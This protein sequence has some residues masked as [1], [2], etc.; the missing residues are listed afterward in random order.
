MNMKRFIFGLAFLATMFAG[1][2]TEPMN[3][4]SITGS[5]AFEALTEVFVPQTKTS[6][7]Q[8][9]Q[10]VW[11]Q[12]DRLAIFRGCTVADEFLVTDS[13]AGKTNGTFNIVSDNSE[14]NGSFSAGTEAPCN[15]A[16]YPYAE[17]I[18]LLGASL[19]AGTAYKIDGVVI[20]AVQNYVAGSFGNGSFPMV[21]V[22]ETISDHTLRFKN[23]LGAMK[24]QFKGA[25]KIVSIKVEGKNNETLSGPA[26]ITAYA[27]DMT[28]AIIMA[29]T[30]DSAKSVTLDCGDGVQLS[31]SIV[32]DFIIALPPVNFSDGFV[33]KVTDADGDSFEIVADVTNTVIRSSI[34]VMP[35]VV[36]DGSTEGESDGG[37][38]EDNE[39][40]I[41]LI[42]ASGLITKAN[43]YGAVDLSNY[44]K[45]ENFD[46]YAYWANEHEGSWFTDA[47][48]FLTSTT[49]GLEFVNKGTSWGGL[50]PYY[51][52]KNGSLRFAAYSP[53]SL[54][55]AHV[56]ETDT[57]IVNDY[58]QSNETDKTC[59]L[60]LAPTSSSKT[61]ENDVYIGFQ[62]ALSW[63]TFKVRATNTESPYMFVIN[64]ITIQDVYT[65]ADLQASMTDGIQAHEWTNHES[66][67]DYIVFDGSQNLS[68]DY[69]NIETIHNG[70][71]LIPQET[72]RVIV[73][74]TMMP[75]GEVQS[76]SMDLHI[77]SDQDFWEPNKH[78]VYSLIFSMHEVLLSLSVTGFN[79]SFNESL[80]VE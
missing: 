29:G 80:W 52:P 62:H 58:I 18:S 21:A 64:R 53:A 42:P 47:T 40:E 70:T 25:Q 28:P 56:L 65:Q 35:M 59:D 50:E 31:E 37:L 34:L 1:C 20:P 48:P 69:V 5:A 13:S 49:S 3:E 55:I 61:A 67:K 78:Y 2:Q 43:I 15:V 17:G 44:P 54:D 9:K 32:T 39:K 12:N 36:L 41:L 71:L 22:T 38:K 75:S 77:G 72:T 7:T 14:L 45:A 57:Y 51:W 76:L 19:D 30:D 66:K 26:T 79:D 46:V 27:D 4:S 8:D 16:L 60:L 23:I 68:M 74:F 63:L 33:V 73:D 24:L 10:V 6:M 11:S